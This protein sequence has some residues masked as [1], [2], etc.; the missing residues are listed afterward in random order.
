MPYENI[1]SG[2]GGIEDWMVS[3]IAESETHD[4]PTGLGFVT[5]SSH[6]S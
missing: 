4:V 1:C 3:S 5:V 6:L 2:T